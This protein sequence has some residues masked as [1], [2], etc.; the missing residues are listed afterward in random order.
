MI[1]RHFLA[2]AVAGASLMHLPRPGAAQNSAIDPSSA[3][4]QELWSL[5][6]DLPWKHQPQPAKLVK[7]EQK[8]GYR[9][10]HLVLD[11]NDQEP[12]PAYLLLPD[13]RQPKAPG[14]L[15]LHAHGGN[16]PRGK[17][18][19]LEGCNVLPAYAPVLAEL[20]VVTLCIDSWCFGERNSQNGQQGEW[21]TF[22]RMLWM[23][24][25]LWGMIVFDD[26]RSLDYLASRPEVDP[27][28]LGVFGL[29]MG[30]TRAWWLA[31][32]DPRIQLC[33]DLCC[34][35]DFQ[36]LL[37]TKNLKG[38]GIY[39]YVPQL[40]KHFQTADINALIAPRR[41][42]S[43]NGRK[44]ALTPPAGVEKIRDQVMPLYRQ[45][46]KPADCRIELFECGHEETPEMRKLVREWLGKL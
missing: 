45:A 31:A 10:D 6:G 20:G 33:I 12:V 40:L 19:L 16:Y 2:G 44:D 35:T 21:D 30:S 4:R 34:L 1:R 23:G 24:Q 11:L 15:Y 36:E 46:E 13:H 38:H 5:L 28:R 42:L 26:F 43:L 41:R 32:L 18:E 8:P 3:R 17:K 37:R 14:L 22:K 29:S 9:L 7:T 39:Y 27:Q 25:V